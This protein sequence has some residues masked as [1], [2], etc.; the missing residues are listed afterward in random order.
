MLLATNLP[1]VYLFPSV[2]DVYSLP[3]RHYKPFLKPLPIAFTGDK[4]NI[5][6]FISEISFLKCKK[7]TVLWSRQ[8]M[9]MQ[10]KQNIGILRELKKRRGVLAKSGNYFEMNF[11][12]IPTLFQKYNL[13]RNSPR[14]LLLIHLQLL[15]LKYWFR[16][17]VNLKKMLTAR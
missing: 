14:W 3:D 2:W 11:H 7:L 13:K 10:I 8:W 6:V 17:S 5:P 12:T 16:I 9:H 4:L 1:F 15:F